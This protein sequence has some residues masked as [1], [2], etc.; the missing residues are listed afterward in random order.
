[1]ATIGVLQGNLIGPLSYNDIRTTISPVIGSG[2]GTNGYGQTSLTTQVSQNNKIGVD[3]WWYLRKDLLTCFQH[4]S[5]LTN[6]DIENVLTS[7]G[8][9][10]TGQITGSTLTVTALSLGTI[11]SG[12]RI[13]IASGSTAFPSG[14]TISTVN[15][16]YFTGYISAGA[17]SGSIGTTLTITSGNT[18]SIGM[19]LS[20]SG[21]TA[22]TYI[23]AGSGSSWTVSGSAQTFGSAGAPASFSAV[24]YTLSASASTPVTSTSLVSSV[25]I[26][27]AD[28]A[29]YNTIATIMTWGSLVTTNVIATPGSTTTVNGFTGYWITVPLDVYY[30]GQPVTVSGNN[31]G[32]GG[33][34]SPLYVAGTTYWIGKIGTPDG[35]GKVT[36]IILTSS[37]SNLINNTYDVTTSAGTP[38]GLRWDF[39]SRLTPPPLTPLAQASRVALDTVSNLSNTGSTPT[40]WGG[41]TQNPSYPQSGRVTVTRVI[42]V[43]FGSDNAARY[44]FNSGGFIEFSSSRKDGT[45][46]TYT[47]NSAYNSVSTKNG[48]WTTL[49]QDMG[50]IRFANDFTY[51][52]GI[53]VPSP[54]SNDPST[55]AVETSIGYVGIN[56]TWQTIFTKTSSY[57]TP[58]NYRI[59]ATNVLGTG[60]VSFAITWN[61]TAVSS[62]IVSGVNMAID[63]DV[64]GCLRSLVQCY[65]PS[66]ASSSTYGFTLTT[67][68]VTASTVNGISNTASFWV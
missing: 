9:Y 12:Q 67:P 5:G 58:N 26:T 32:T 43:N 6:A 34:L 1:M 15:T 54:S 62:N 41:T 40:V 37:Y 30:I 39:R 2:S 16:A 31:T 51:A 56:N 28:R 45:S 64:T 29:A 36:Q 42:T 13:S 53:T 60:Q 46:P 18:P 22:G 35:N 33:I 55:N 14:V 38:Q 4:I 24:S 10:F 52:S 19:T 48:L 44:F 59:Q 68:S 65:I 50:S 3:Q 17:G 47:D 23:T 8:A 61:D 21:L 49:L 20:S 27:A 57:Y 11:S 25:V 63:E 66:G 7:P